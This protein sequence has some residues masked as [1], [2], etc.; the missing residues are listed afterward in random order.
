MKFIV[1]RSS[2]Q[3]TTRIPGNKSATARAIILAALAEGASKVGNCLPGLDSFSIVEMMR[4]L[5]AKIDT[6][7]PD[8]WTFEG[9]ANQPQVPACVLDAGNSGTGYYQIAAIASLVN[10]CSVVS[11]DYQ[12]CRRPAQ[13]LIEALNDLGA[14][15]VS[16]RGNGLAPLVVKGPMRGGKTKLP[17]VNS[18]W[19]SPLLIAGGLTPEGITVVEDNLME[20]PYVDMTMGWI[21]TAG[22]QVSHDNYD[23]F[24]VPGGQ[25]YKG[26]TAD[27]PADWGSSGYPMVAAAVTDSKVT[28][29]GMNPDDYAGEKAY[30]HIIKAMGGKVTFE[31]EGRT[32][33][34]E[35]GA[36]LQG[37][38]ID[39]SGTPDAVPALAVLGCKAQGKTRLYNIEASRLKET[40]RTRSIME[41]LMKMGG[42]FDETEG[43]LTVYHSELK[44]TRIDGRHDHRIV[45]ATAVA[46]MMAD[47]ETMIDDAEYVGVSFPNFYEVMTSLGA[48]IHRMEIV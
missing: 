7:K 17:G 28:F 22:G 21:R 2:L 39:C 43:S 23:V 13:P 20:R 8:Y 12:I 32:V 37:I 44:G 33:T 47:G 35:G 18:Q 3:G 11:G 15:V 26:F 16:T 45:M 31:D 6:S 19:L 36:E 14:D 46:A 48:G 10:G 41:E 40:D 29:T 9:V 5:G 38:E 42:K 1:T 25:K 4:A 24:T 30:P 34:V 27:I